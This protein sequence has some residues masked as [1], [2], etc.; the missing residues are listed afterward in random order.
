MRWEI[1]EIGKVSTAT[2]TPSWSRKPATTRG[3]PGRK[4]WAHH[5]SNLNLRT[6]KM[7][8]NNHFKIAYSGSIPLNWPHLGQFQSIQQTPFI[9]W[10]F[11]V[12]SSTCGSCCA[13]WECWSLQRSSARHSMKEELERWDLYPGSPPRQRTEV[14]DLLAESAPQCRK[15]H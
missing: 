6:T 14:C 12:S 4:D 9:M 13:V 7:R 3:T 15:P 2:T 5:L 1:L 10:C 8:K 11:T